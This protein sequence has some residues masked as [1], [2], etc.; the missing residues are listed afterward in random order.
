MDVS[1][2]GRIA[3][4]IAFGAENAGTG[5]SNDLEKLSKIARD[6]VMRFGF[7]EKVFWQ[8]WIY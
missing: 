4:E 6:F 3:E 1:L 7:S 5:A 8:K 2:A